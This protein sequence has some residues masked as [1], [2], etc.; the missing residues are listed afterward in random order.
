MTY[1][2]SPTARSGNCRWG[3]K[4]SPSAPNARKRSR[5]PRLKSN[6]RSFLAHPTVGCGIEFLVYVNVNS[7]AGASPMK[8]LV[9]VKRVVDYN[10][11]V[12]VKSDNTGVD[13]ANVKMSMNPFD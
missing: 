7:P 10:V 1:P 8:V 4:S 3:D 13:I 9:P 12:R 5:T 6:G 11:K 2:D